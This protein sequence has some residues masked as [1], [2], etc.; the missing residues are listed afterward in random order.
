VY[1]HQTLAVGLAPAT[2]EQ[3][4]LQRRRWGMGAMQILTY[5][6]LWAAKR[7][8]SWRNFH[9]YL[10]GT[11]WWLEGIATL[12][13]FI[14]PTTVMLTGAQ[15]STAKP[16]VFAGAFLAMF[17]VRMW[18]AK[19]LLRRQIHWPTAFALRIFRVPVGIACLWWLLSRSRLQF[20]VTPKA[21]QDGRRR[22]RIPRILWTLT[23]LIVGV[24]SY[25]V[26]GIAGWVPWH[27]SA[28]STAASG[29]WL[30]LATLVLF[31][32]TRRIRASEFATS[33]RNGYRVGLH[34]AV[35]VNGVPGEL[36]DISVGG[37]AAVLPSTPE[38][39]DALIEVLL[40]GAA[41]MK[42]KLVS[43]PQQFGERGNTSLKLAP[44]D[45]DAYRT[46]ALW[47][48]HTPSGAVPALP[49]GV[50]VVAIR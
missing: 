23:A 45:W 17:S 38:P 50:P 10:S 18:G 22:G 7:W 24:A 33:R 16:L 37:I 41:A 4:L 3:Y 12:V 35:L 36:V 11:L 25:A 49:D 34:A 13:A 47:M 21:G 48:F 43:G 26:A 1:H 19:R 28:G 31:L 29:V 27:T 44:G 40:P 42:L 39:S 30:A 2:P 5:E 20:E 14:V 46:M 15:T 9:E 6:R 32:G 8:M